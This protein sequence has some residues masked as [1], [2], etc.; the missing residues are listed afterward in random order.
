[1]IKFTSMPPILLRLPNGVFQGTKSSSTLRDIDDIKKSAQYLQPRKAMHT[2]YMH[3]C[4][5]I[6][7]IISIL[8]KTNLLG[9]NELSVYVI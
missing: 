2:R 1:M 7:Y 6:A 8:L 4:Y 3:G 9:Q 5:E